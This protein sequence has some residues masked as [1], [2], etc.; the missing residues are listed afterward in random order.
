MLDLN[1]VRVFEKVA[2]T[3]GFATAARALAMPKSSVSRSIARLEEELGARLFQRTTRD[4]VLT[5][6]GEELK[7]RCSGLLRRL[8]EA[9]NGVRSATSLP[10]GVLRVSAAIGFGVNVLA[11]ELPAFLARHPGLKLS[12]DLST[13]VVDL[14]AEGV[15]VAIRLGPM[16][17]SGLVSAHLG[18]MTRHLCAAPSYLERRGTPASL[19]EILE[20]DTI[21]APGIDGR[22]RRWTLTR[23][24]E[25]K[26]LEIQPRVSVNE[27]LTLHKLVL[28][29]A[30][31]GIISGYVCAPAFA[32][33]KLVRLF[34]EW[35]LPSIEVNVVFPSKHELDPNV[36]EFVNFMKE[37]TTPGRSWL[38][39]PDWPSS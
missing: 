29:G 34:P 39:E 38:N 5:P 28:N 14:L 12:V 31:I 7:E 6:A 15:D 33:G 17:S 10:R 18:S 8:E 21:E 35:S 11:D 23:N 37:V 20:H 25:T 27:A 19:D 1:D 9:V 4:V 3:N 30:G 24:G 26:D 13:R 16:P 22:P 2:A 36:R 32:S